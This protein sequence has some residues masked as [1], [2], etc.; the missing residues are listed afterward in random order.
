MK[1]ILNYLDAHM[2]LTASRFVVG[3]FVGAWAIA[4]FGIGP[5]LLVAVIRFPAIFYVL[6]V[7]LFYVLFAVAVVFLVLMLF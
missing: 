3:L 6:S 5:Y 4:M 1:R 2:N 7:I